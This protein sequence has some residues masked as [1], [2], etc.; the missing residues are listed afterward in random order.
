MSTRSYWW[1]IKRSNKGCIVPCNNRAVTKFLSCWVYAASRWETEQP[2]SSLYFILLMFRL[3][4][5][6][7]HAH[8][9][10]GKSPTPGPLWQRWIKSPQKLEL[11]QWFCWLFAPSATETW[12]NSELNQRCVWA[13]YINQAPVVQKVD[14]AIYGIN[15]LPLD[16]VIGFPNSYRWDSDL[17]SG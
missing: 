2:K 12:R 7:D 8:S 16:S 4:V 9:S 5:A 11:V 14:N 15:H 1:Y 13:M 3:K 6:R 17:S 10:W